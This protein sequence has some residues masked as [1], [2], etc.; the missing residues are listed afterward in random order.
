MKDQK[1]EN[2]VLK[3]IVAFNNSDGGL[4]LIGVEN[5]NNIYGLEDD[6][7]L[8]GL[9]DKDRFELH[10]KNILRS[11]LKIENEYIARNIEIK[12]ENIDG[13]DICIVDVKKGV[14][15]NRVWSRSNRRADGLGQFSTVA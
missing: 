9:K 15:P 6:Y 4:L 10:L 13:K 2:S 3:T 1:I 7:N 8:A 12:F 11:R 5:N 14:K